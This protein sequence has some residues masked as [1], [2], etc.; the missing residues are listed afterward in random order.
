MTATARPESEQAE[1]GVESGPVLLDTNVLVY[2]TNRDSPFY[3]RAQQ[4]LQQALAGEPAAC[5]TPQILAE[6]YA[7]ITDPRRVESPLTPRQARAQIEALLQALE[8]LPLRASSS[9]QMAELAERYRIRAQEVYDVQ[10]VAAM[11]DHGISTILTANE[12]DF[13]RFAEIE[14]RNPFA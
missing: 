11:L 3:D 12:R 1:A 2:A 7:V 9:R 14:V 13:R 6:Y 4:V 10:V 8:V 5:L